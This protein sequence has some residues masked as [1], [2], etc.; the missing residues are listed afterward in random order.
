MVFTRKWV[1]GSG[2]PTYYSWRSMRSRCLYPANPSWKH[3]GGRGITVCDRW[4]DYDDFIEDMG[5][6]PE[7]YTLER[8]DNNSGYSPENCRW[9]TVRDQLNNQRRNRIVEYKGKRQ[10]VGQWASELG[11]KFDTLWRR[12][13]RMPVE[14]ALTPES[15]MPKWQHGTKRGYEAYKCR[16]EVCREAHNARMREYRRKRKGT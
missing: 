16:C 7:G 2:T 1:N 9:A 8:I 12:L 15:L 13:S 10:T 3:Y 6:R 11:I 14:K 4:L 5:E